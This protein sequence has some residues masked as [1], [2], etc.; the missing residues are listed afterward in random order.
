MTAPTPVGANKN[1][2]LISL[3]I[4]VTENEELLGPLI[5]IGN[6]STQTVL[7]FDMDLDPPTNHAVIAVGGGGVLPSGSSIVYR[8]RVFV[9]GQL[10]DAVAI[11]P[12]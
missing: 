9:S 12:N 8:G 2:S 3:N 10:T 4:I 7:T 6:D 1:E 5:A 11:R